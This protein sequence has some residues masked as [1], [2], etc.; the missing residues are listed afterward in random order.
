M[1]YEFSKRLPLFFIKSQFFLAIANP[2]FGLTIPVTS[3]DA[4]YESPGSLGAALYSAE[5]GDVIDCSPIAA[6]VVAI[7][8][9]SLPPIGMNFTSPSASLT[10]L[11]NGIII[12]GGGFV[13]LFSLAM[14][15]VV[16]TDLTIQNGCSLGGSGGFGLTGGGGGTGGGGALYIHTGTTMTLSSVSLNNNQAVGGSGGN[17]NASGGSGGGGGGYGGGNGGFASAIGSTVG[18]AGGGGGHSGGTNGGRDGGVGSPNSFSNFGGAGGGGARPTPPSAARSGG[19]VAASLF[20]PAHSGGIAGVS[21]SEA[22]AG[23]GGGAGSGGSGFGGSSAS[24]SLGGVGGRGGI[25]FGDDYAYGC[26][27]GGGGG[28]GGGA[29]VGSSG[30]GGGLNGTGGSGGSLGGGGGASNF[31][32]G[33]GGF[34]AGGGGGLV[35]GNDVYGLGGSGGSANGLPAGGGG[36]AGLGG[37]I[38]IQQGATLIIED[39]VSF[40]SNSTTA[41]MGGT[42]ASGGSNGKNGS[43]FGQDIFIRSGGSLVFQANGSLTVPHPIEGGGLLSEASGPGVTLSGVGMVNLSGTNTYLGG[44]L[45]QSGT[46]NLNGSVSGDLH[47]NSAGT[48]SGGA[49]VGG[50]IYSSGTISPGSSI[51][52][53]ITTNLYLDSTS[54]YSVEVTPSSC[55]LLQL[56]GSATLA[57]T[58]EVTQ[59]LGSY[60]SSGEYCI[61]QT[62]EGIMDSFDSIMVHSLPGFQFNLQNRSQGLF[63]VYNLIPLS[64]TNLQSQQIKNQFLGQTD[65][66]NRVK[67][68]QSVGGGTVPV[69]YWIYRDNLSTLIGSIEADQPLIFEDHN[70]L[71]DRVYT[72]YIVAID[73]ENNRSVP[74]NIT[75]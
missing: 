28:N 25:G 61:L 54:L 58:L 4:S 41:G 10:I 62:T 2:L 64:P 56:T 49:T 38:F 16:I 35:G 17:G 32:G 67:W 65:I 57:G 72:Y 52:E 68:N 33:A 11:G 51:S 31:T 1:F 24:G 27:G 47:I 59:D 63:L 53:I 48:L 22:A 75:L 3:T 14:G 39:D 45:I 37:A 12:D 71:K 74:V 34:G 60:G 55:G 20:T 69:V 30:G 26:G 21:S 50:S 73:A 43:S 13:P 36:G 23:G 44:T 46:L 6:Q 18:A 5:D 9:H 42:A 19:T 70:R 66:V 29:G 15:S 8:A 40:S 7:T